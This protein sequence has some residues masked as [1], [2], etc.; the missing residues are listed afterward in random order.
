MPGPVK[1]WGVGS[2]RQ[3]HPD[4][5]LMLVVLIVMFDAFANFRGRH[6][7]DRVRVR[8]VVGWPVED[9]HAEDALFELVGLAGQCSR[10]YKS[11]EPR[12]SFAGME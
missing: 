10:D 9:F 12:I 1:L 5:V 4:F 2:C 11:E 3:N 6:S 8:I 7:N